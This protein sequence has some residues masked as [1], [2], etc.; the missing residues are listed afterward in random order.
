M[1]MASKSKRKRA[2]SR[3]CGKGSSLCW[4]HGI[5]D[6]V[7]SEEL[8]ANLQDLEFALPA[9]LTLEQA[10]R[11]MSARPSVDTSRAPF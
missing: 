9:P 10:M 5:I 7:V 4:W 1:L 2:K 6:R 8:A 11:W 3:P